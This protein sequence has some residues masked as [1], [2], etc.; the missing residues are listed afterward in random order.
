MKYIGGILSLL[1]AVVFLIP[2]SWMLI[3][4]IKVEGMAITGVL[5]WYKPP[6]SIEMYVN[7][8][9]D[10]PLIRWMYNSLIVAIAVTFVTVI[11]TSMAAFALSKI[12]FRF[13]RTMFLFILAGLMVPGEATIIS[14][15]QIAKELGLLDS[16][17]G[18][19]LPSIASPF[20]VIVLMSFFN[21]V[22]KELI[23]SAHIDGS[24]YLRI[25]YQIVV[26]LSKPVLA[27]IAILTFIGQW[28]NF[29]WPFLSLSSEQLFTLPMGIPTLISQFSE[30]YVRPMTI[31]SI[32][33]IP[34]IVI[35][36]LF[37]RQIVKGLSFTGLKG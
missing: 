2:I 27:S 16:Y 34:V 15:Y 22:P 31:N 37:E 18:L 13:K 24:G 25:F 9:G 7:V 28:N 30:D 8:I 11:F 32:V 12:N 6:Y 26:P 17:S 14:L 1:L 33:S 19:I 35:F 3:V 23:E 21:G 4:S 5:D 10:T 29:L 36:L 20:A